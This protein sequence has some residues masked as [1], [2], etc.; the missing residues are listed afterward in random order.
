MQAHLVKVLKNT[1][2]STCVNGMFQHLTFLCLIGRI[3][4][5]IFLWRGKSNEGQMTNNL[6]ITVH[7]CQLLFIIA[8]LLNIDM[9]MLMEILLTFTDPTENCILNLT[10]H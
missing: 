6:S 9:P 2:T 3:C 1:Y 4:A 8:N 5:Y 10:L 7:Y